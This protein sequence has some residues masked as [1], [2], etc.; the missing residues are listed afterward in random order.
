MII[1]RSL[2]VYFL[3]PQFGF[4]WVC[5]LSSRSG[6]SLCRV[7]MLSEHM[8]HTVLVLNCPWEKF[9]CYSLSI[10]ALFSVSAFLSLEHAVWNYFSLTQLHRW[11]PRLWM[12][13]PLQSTLKILMFIK[14]MLWQ[15]NASLSLYIL[16]TETVAKCF[17]F[18][19]TCTYWRGLCHDNVAIWWPA[20][21]LE[22]STV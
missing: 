19:C 18:T 17:T 16:H 13:L 12:W 9:A 22:I 21:W 8:R 3:C 15:G 7:A 20:K 1:S 5:L 11:L 4:E 6:A 2:D 14:L 10:L